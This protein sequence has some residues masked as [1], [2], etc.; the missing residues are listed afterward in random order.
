MA[1]SIRSLAKH[2]GRAESTV[3]KW[4]QSDDW[5]PS[6]GLEPPWQ[7]AKVRAWMEIY[8]KA[9]PSAAYRKKIRS[10]EAGNGVG[11]LSPLNKARLQNYIERALWIRQQREK[12][13]GKLHRTDE[14]IK[15]YAGMVHKAKAS[16]LIVGRSMRN[17]L[18]GQDAETIERLLNERMLA[19][20]K[21][22]EDIDE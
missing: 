14:C 16:A 15:L 13:A 4:L 11:G 3:R 9:D 12:D 5:P 2:V 7:V 6:F 21:I 19:I 20:L 1:N 8:P 22:L 17:A 18:L 10:I